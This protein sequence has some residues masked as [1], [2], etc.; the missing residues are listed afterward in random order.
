MRR[1]HRRIP[2]QRLRESQ[3]VMMSHNCGAILKHAFSPRS[4]LRNITLGESFNSF[5]KKAFIGC[6]YTRFS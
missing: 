3:S 4:N 1:C 2:I 5:A 6:P